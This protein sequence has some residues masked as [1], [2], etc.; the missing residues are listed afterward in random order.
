M[1]LVFNSGAVAGQRRWLRGLRAA[2]AESTLT[3]LIKF[4]I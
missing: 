4:H 3:V 1:S 2:F